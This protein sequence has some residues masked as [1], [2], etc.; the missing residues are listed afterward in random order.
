MEIKTIAVSA[1]KNQETLALYADLT[2]SDD[3][4]QSY[5]NLKAKVYKLL[6]KTPYKEDNKKD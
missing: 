1:T 6:N 3:I 5:L 4:N 2:P